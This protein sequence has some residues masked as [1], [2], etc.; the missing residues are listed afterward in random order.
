MAAKIVSQ[1][2]LIAFLRIVFGLIL[3]NLENQ[4]ILLKFGWKMLII[5]KFKF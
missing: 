2:I 3:K 4:K 5:S 1:F